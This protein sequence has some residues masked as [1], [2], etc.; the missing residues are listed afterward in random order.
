MDNQK[1][2]VISGIIAFGLW[3]ILPLY[4]G[5]LSD[6][7]VTQILVNRIFWSFFTLLI[8][9]VLSKRRQCLIV[10]KA[11]GQDKKKLA[12]LILS[13]LLLSGNW[14]LYIHAMTSGQILEASLGYY[15]NPIISILL[16]VTFLKERLSGYQLVAAILAGSAV[17]FLT[18]VQ[19]GPPWIAV[20][21]ALSFGFYG[22]LKKI[23]NV[24]AM[25][26]LWF[27][28]A[29]ML[30]VAT[31]FFFSWIIQGTSA[32]AN[33]QPFHTF[34]LTAAGLMT[35]APLFFF[36]KAATLL[37]LK[38][39]GFLQYIQPTM[40]FFIAIFITGEPFSAISLIAFAIIWIACLLF[41]L[42]N[43]LIKSN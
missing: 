12:L 15:I 37:P 26:S 13:A 25:I 29:V 43:F 10:I 27:E 4:W 17:L 39:L 41:S 38:T 30:P 7:E 21:V 35:I 28:M 24:D 23:L 2:G 40:Q 34:L 42:S 5:I 20:G 1:Q 36:S 16:G 19:G 8:L 31:F 11:L 14:F 9:I 18:L 33:A 6:I 3:G 32:Y 22:L